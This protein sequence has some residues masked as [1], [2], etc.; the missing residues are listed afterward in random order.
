M[1]IDK[2]RSFFPHIKKDIF[3]LN[4]AARGP[5]CTPV[6][7]SLNKAIE[8]QSSER[9][10]DYQSFLQTMEATRNLIG[11]MLNTQTDRIGFLD[12]TTNGINVVANGIKWKKGDRILLNDLEFPA[13]VYPFLNL[14]NE[15]VEVDF[16]KSQDGIISAEK[17]IEAIKPK[18]KLLS[19]SYVQFLSGYRVNLEEIGIVC[20]ERG[21][22]FSVDAIQALGA[23]NLDVEKCKV[24]F[25]SC[26]AQKW[27]LGLQG[28]A[29]IFIAKHLQ[30]VMQPKNIGWLSV[31]DAWNLLH[32]DLHLKKSAL[33]FQG[34]T[35]NN[36]GVYALHSALEL[37]IEFGLNNIESNIISNS[38]YVSQRLINWVTL[39][40]FLI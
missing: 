14:R 6:I 38:K 31:E 7:N 24:D 26:G 18:T 22:I 40:R 3:F 15:G 20:R 19:I 12:N 27:L 33:A 30:E 17:I 23:V 1:N 21:I 34:G 13:N 39:L 16:V 37:F 36:L 5:L 29:F 32:Y 8:E 10:D 9:I 35:V 28:F 4:H 25:L 2:V 11:K